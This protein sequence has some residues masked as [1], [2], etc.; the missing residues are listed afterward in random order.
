MSLV[1]Y[2]KINIGKF[3]RGLVLPQMNVP[4]CVD[5]PWEAVPVGRSGWGWAGGERRAGGGVGG[6]TLVGM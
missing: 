6:R 5:S 4:N 1:T 2:R 3:F